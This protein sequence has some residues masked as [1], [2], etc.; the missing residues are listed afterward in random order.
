[1]VV[2]LGSPTGPDLTRIAPD[3]PTE[4]KQ[5]DRALKDAKTYG[6]R[7]KATAELLDMLGLAPDSFTVG[8]FPRQRDAQRLPPVR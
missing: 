6:I 7:V 3:W 8:R 4:S 2:D 1:M 5:R